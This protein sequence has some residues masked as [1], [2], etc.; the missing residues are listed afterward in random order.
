MMSTPSDSISSMRV[1]HLGSIRPTANKAMP[2]RQT[3]N[4]QT[5]RRGRASGQSDRLSSNSAASAIRRCF[6]R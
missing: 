4:F 1:P 6:Q 5:A 3:R 2:V